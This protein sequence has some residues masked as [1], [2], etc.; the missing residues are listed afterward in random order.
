[1]PGIG[2]IGDVS[3]GGAPLVEESIWLG[4]GADVPDNRYVYH[5]P[6][7]LR[8][9]IKERKIELAR[10][11][12]EISEAEIRKQEQVLALQNDRKKQ[13][14]LEKQLQE[15]INVL[16]IQRAQLIRLIDEEEAIL[17]LLM[18]LPFIN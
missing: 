16:V 8:E 15:E 1:M 3:I 5:Q 18:S 7:T 2:G 13:K 10:V 11:E 9:T 17:V 12:E 4:G 6:G 14:K